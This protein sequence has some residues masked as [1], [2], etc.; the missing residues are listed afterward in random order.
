MTSPDLSLLTP[1]HGRE[2]T[3]LPVSVLGNDEQCRL[4]GGGKKP[5]V[6]FIKHHRERCVRVR[7]GPLGNL[8]ASVSAALQSRI[9]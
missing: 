6:G 3:T 8:L 4:A 7:Q 2:V 9:G 1:A 5:M